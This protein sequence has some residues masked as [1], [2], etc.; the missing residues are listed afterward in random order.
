MLQHLF[1]LVTFLLSFLPCGEELTVTPSTVV[2]LEW[3]RKCILSALD[4]PPDTMPARGDGHSVPVTLRAGYRTILPPFPHLPF[5]SCV[6][7]PFSSPWCY[8][9]ELV[10]DPFLVSRIIVEI[11]PSLCTQK[12]LYH[13]DHSPLLQCPEW[14][15]NIGPP[16]EDSAVR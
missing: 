3:H 6:S 5:Q 13:K 12:H 16:G 7:F 11:R 10:L 8:H 15:T 1:C 2:L 4:P 9:C 14:F